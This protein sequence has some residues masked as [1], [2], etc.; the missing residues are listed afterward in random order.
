MGAFSQQKQ[1]KIGRPVTHYTVLINRPGRP[2]EILRSFEVGPL[3]PFEF[4][5]DLFLRP[6]KKYL[7]E[8]RKQE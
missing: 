7:K 6:P 2:I 8:K 1:Q 4:L 5:S 3:I